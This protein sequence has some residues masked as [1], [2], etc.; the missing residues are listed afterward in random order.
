MIN[1]RFSFF[2]LSIQVPL[3][4]G[5]VEQALDMAQWWAHSGG[6]A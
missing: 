4:F 3:K 1:N 6:Y 5:S 2:R